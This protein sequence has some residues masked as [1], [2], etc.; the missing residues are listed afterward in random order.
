MTTDAPVDSSVTAKALPV[1]QATSQDTLLQSVSWICDH[2]GVGKSPETLTAGLPKGVVGAFVGLGGTVRRQFVG[3]SGDGRIGRDPYRRK[4]H[5]GLP[6]KA[7]VQR[8]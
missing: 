2:Y 4:D 8:T 3:H 6:V 7:R 5:S 1:A